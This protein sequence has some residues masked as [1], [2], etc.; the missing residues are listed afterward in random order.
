MNMSSVSVS[1]CATTLWSKLRCLVVATRP[2]EW[3]KNSFLF[4]ALFFSKN[5]LS[6]ALLSKVVLAFGLY[7]LAA[8]GVYLLNDIRDRHTDLQHPQKRTRP[9]ASGALPVA[10]AAAV[11][12]VF[13]GVA[14]GG[15][16]L[17]HPAFGYI[18]ASYVLL[19]VAYTYW[20]KRLVILD[21]FSLATGFVLRVVAG[22]VVIEVMMSYWLLICTMLLA[23]LLGFSKR[24]CELVLLDQAARQ[25]RPVLAEYNL[26]FLD[27]MI[28]VV[29]SAAMVSYTLYT[30]SPETTHKFH[31][32]K[33]FLS[34]PVVL[35]GLFRYLYL[36]YHKNSGGNPAHT[37]LTDTPLQ[38]SVVLWGLV[39]AIILYTAHP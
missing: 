31:T 1:V 9:I 28:G 33:L 24:R 30:V 36:V 11:M 22:A 3:I 34:V 8:S 14:L 18:I 32:D 5:L 12:V 29:T 19:N 38:A 2:R 39:S 15:A 16:W 26:P 37:L 4:A 35:Y 27:T 20:L 17:L 25:H 23:L 10:L 7:C 6:F 21:V 13:L